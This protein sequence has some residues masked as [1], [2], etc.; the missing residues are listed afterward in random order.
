MKIYSKLGGEEFIK[1]RGEQ[2]FKKSD[3]MFD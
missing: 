1:N 2:I 3:F